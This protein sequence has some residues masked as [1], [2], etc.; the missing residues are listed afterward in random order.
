MMS[1]SI[2][3]AAGRY[4]EVQMALSSIA[5]K[6]CV[7]DAVSCVID[8]RPINGESSQSI[9]TGHNEYAVDARYVII[10]FLSSSAVDTVDSNDVCAIY[11]LQEYR[12]VT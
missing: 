7:T 12:T 11:A 5:F 8:K 10:K 6:L 9:V 2:S 3:S 4:N 1:F